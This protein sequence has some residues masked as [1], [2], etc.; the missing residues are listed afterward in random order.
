MFSRPREIDARPVIN[1]GPSRTKQ[2]FKH[3]ADIH[4]ILAKYTRTGTLNWVNNVN[5]EFIETDP[6]EFQDAMNLIV[7]ARNEFDKLPAAVRR[8]FDYDPQEFL[9]EAGQE[10]SREKFERL[11]LIEVVEKVAEPSPTG[12][13]APATPA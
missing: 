1:C 10:S 5:P 4:R 8:E 12:D 6:I 2:E 9:K 3:D 13:P 11:G 7:N